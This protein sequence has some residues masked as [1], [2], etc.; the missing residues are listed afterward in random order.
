VPIPRWYHAKITQ[1]FKDR[2]KYALPGQVQRG[3]QSDEEL[4][5]LIEDVYTEFPI[6]QYLK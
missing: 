6:D 3:V 5:Q 2:L 4:Q 1:A